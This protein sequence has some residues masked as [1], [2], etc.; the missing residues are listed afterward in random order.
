MVAD[1]YYF[2]SGYYVSFLGFFLD[3]FPDAGEEIFLRL[4]DAFSESAEI[5]LADNKGDK[6]FFLSPFWGQLLGR[7]Q[8]CSESPR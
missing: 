7:S 1:F 4:G 5:A 3:R 8:S 6:L 2:K